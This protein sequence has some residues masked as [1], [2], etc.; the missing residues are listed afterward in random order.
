MMSKCDFFE[1]TAQILEVK[2]KGKNL[3]TT[4]AAEQM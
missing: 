1:Q 2:I 3:K 4:S